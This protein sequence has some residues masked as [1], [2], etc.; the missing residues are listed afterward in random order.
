MI[1]DVKL[2]FIFR[3]ITCQCYISSFVTCFACTSNS[4]LHEKGILVFAVVNVLFHFSLQTI[5]PS[6]FGKFVFI[7]CRY[8]NVMSL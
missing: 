2:C 3:L 6:N 7:H 8:V 1:N 4:K 5:Q